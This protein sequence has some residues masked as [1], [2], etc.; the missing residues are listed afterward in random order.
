[1]GY[2]KKVTDDVTVYTTQQMKAQFSNTSFPAGE[3]PENAFAQLGI[4][5][6]ELAPYPTYDPELE[7]PV[8]D[9]CEKILNIWYTKWRIVEIQFD[10]LTVEAN[11]KYELSELRYEKESAGVS[12]WGKQIDTDKVSQAMLVT[13]LFNLEHNFVSIAE[14][15]TREGKWITCTLQ[16]LTQIADLVAKH[17][18]SCFVKEQQLLAKF[19]ALATTRERV[20]FNLRNEW[21]LL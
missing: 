21:D 3:I 6:V 1:M 12:I 11:K 18:Q 17:V 13:T 5:A 4:E 7:Y 16:E 14:W 9:G 8:L 19:T 2:Y 15:K 20:K 10:P